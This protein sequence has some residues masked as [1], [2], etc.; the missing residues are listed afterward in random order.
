VADERRHRSKDALLLLATRA[1]RDGQETVLRARVSL[2]RATVAEAEAALEQAK[3]RCTDVETQ[4]KRVAWDFAWQALAALGLPRP[5]SND[6]AW[7]Y[8]DDGEVEI[9]VRPKGR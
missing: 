7:A 4:E 2:A 3:R 8:V 1:F 6:E 9:V 5:S